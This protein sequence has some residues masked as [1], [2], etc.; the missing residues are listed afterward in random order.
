[1]VFPSALGNL[2]FAVT[3]PM[4][5]QPC[6]NRD[7]FHHVGQA[8]L[9]RS[10]DL[11]I[12]P[13]W[14]P[15]VLGLQV[16][17]LLP[18]LACSGV[19]L[20]HCNI[21]LSGSSD[22]PTLASR[23][24][25]GGRSKILALC[26]LIVN[27][28]AGTYLYRVSPDFSKV[29]LQVKAE[30]DMGPE[31]KPKCSR[32]GGRDGVSLYCLGWSAVARS[33]LTATSATWVQAILLP[34][35]PEQSLTLLPRV[36]FSGGILAQR[37]LCLL[38][39]SDSHASASL[40]AGTAGVCHHTWLIFLWSFT[41]SPR[42][43]CSGMISAHCKL[44][45]LVSSDSP[46]PASQT[47]SCSVTQV[48]SG[49]ITAHCSL[50]LLGS[51]NPPTSA[52]QVAEVGGLLAYRSTGSDYVTQAGL[53]LLGSSN[54]PTLAC[55]TAGITD[56]VSLLSPRLECN[57]MISA[58]RNL[59]FPDSSNSAS[60]PGRQRFSMLARMVLNSQPQV[61]QLSRLPK[62]TATPASQ[63]QVI[64]L[65]SFLSSWD[66]R[67]ECSGTISAHCNLRLPGS[68]DSHVS[69]SLVARTTGAHHHTQLIFVFLVEM[70]FHHVSQAGLELLISSDW[71]TSA[72]QNAGI[73]GVSHRT[74]PF[75][76][77]GFCHAA[78]AGLEL[79]S[80]GDSPALASQSAGIKV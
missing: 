3:P 14:P 26:A 27:Q 59:H 46:T 6:A 15:K 52:S 32:K 66:H 20:A 4:A 41:L 50:D 18:R 76:K 60:V 69:A 28:K 8:G 1:M 63:V 57:G 70:G 24:L 16:L 10:P 62:L 45:L 61:I 43:E 33:Q 51:R 64:L 7:G 80:S 39:S 21:C 79:L 31:S 36:D 17:A 2:S 25:V 56:R 72:S 38:G 13:P 74:R 47:V 42:L 12:R 53:K 55:Q 29:D 5:N 78:Q 22:S 34:K 11:V 67:L 9:D 37:N 49:T 30:L 73:T 54:P 58:H 44:C 23:V 19:I 35:P 68:S 77:A 48:C 40:V 71:P 75:A 65:L